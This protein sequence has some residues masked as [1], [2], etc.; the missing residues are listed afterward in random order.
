MV[1]TVN[2]CFILDESK[3]RY[4]KQRRMNKIYQITKAGSMRVYDTVTPLLRDG[5]IILG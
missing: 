1:F 5:S 4:R 3:R 2:W